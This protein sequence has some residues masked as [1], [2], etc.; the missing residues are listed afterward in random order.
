LFYYV[1]K[2]EN[3]GNFNPEGD[4]KPSPSFFAVVAFAVKI[5]RIPP[6][7]SAKLRALRGFPCFYMVFS[8]SNREQMLKKK[9]LA[10]P[11]KGLI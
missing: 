5:L 9:T 11:K 1:L 4:Q 8:L 10:P 7:P 3:R 6:S 2:R